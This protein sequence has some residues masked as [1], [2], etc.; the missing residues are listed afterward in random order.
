MYEENILHFHYEVFYILLIGA[1]S[2]WSMGRKFIQKRT[3]LTRKISHLALSVFICFKIE[4]R[5]GQKSLKA[6]KLYKHAPDMDTCSMKR[7]C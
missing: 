6:A 5:I 2:F 7:G 1:Q 4:Q 3:K